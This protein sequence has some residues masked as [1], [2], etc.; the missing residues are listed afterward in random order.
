M[1]SSAEGLA[2][3][4]HPRVCGEHCAG[5]VFERFHRGSSPRMRG[6]PTRKALW[7]VGMGIIPAYAGST[8]SPSAFFSA[9]W[10]HPRVCGEH[11]IGI[12]LRH[13][14]HGIIPAYAG[15]TLSRLSRPGIGRDHPRVCGEHLRFATS[16]VSAEGSSPRMRGALSRV[17]LAQYDDGIIPAYAGSTQPRDA[18]LVDKE[19][20]PRVCGEHLSSLRHRQS[21][22]GS[23]PRMRGALLTSF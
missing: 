13:L 19:D 15:S 22:P 1:A 14:R 8:T 5:G 11:A 17:E 6:A 23:S 16:L 4:D 9:S 10:D 18:A 2:S 21:L 7:Q 3:R 12:A 20:H